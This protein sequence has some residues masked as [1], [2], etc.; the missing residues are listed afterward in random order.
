[1]MIGSTWNAI[2]RRT[3]PSTCVIVPVVGERP[4]DERRADAR[5][6][7][8]AVETVAEGG[9]Q[10]GAGGRLE[11]DQREDD[12]KQQAPGDGAHT[13]SPGGSSRTR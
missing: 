11:D 13:E 4:E 8:Q 7:H 1:M 2:T 3:G 10:R 9:E 6:A 12:L 5:E